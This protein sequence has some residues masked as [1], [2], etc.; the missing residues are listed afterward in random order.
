MGRE[1]LL[2]LFENEC[3][4]ESE[5]AR[6]LKTECHE[7]NK[8]LQRNPKSYSSFHHR[9]WCIEQDKFQ[10]IDLS[11][12]LVLCSDFLALDSR[13]FHCWDYRRFI[14]KKLGQKR[15]KDEV[16]YTKQLIIANFSNY[17]AWH[18]RSTLIPI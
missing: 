14:A 16:K 18:Y 6:L 9:L 10:S 5:R 11:K 15:Q 3:D 7:I 17:S 2:H 1:I 13:N 8:T 12:E 4:S